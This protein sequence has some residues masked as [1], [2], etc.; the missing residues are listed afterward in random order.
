MDELKFEEL[1]KKTASSR[2]ENQEATE[3]IRNKVVS[4]MI[5]TGRKELERIDHHLLEMPLSVITY[6]WI[7]IRLKCRPWRLLIPASFILSFLFQGLLSRINIL[8]LFSK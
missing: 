4:K 5:A 1:M 3:I 6:Q 2:K 7:V 8:Q